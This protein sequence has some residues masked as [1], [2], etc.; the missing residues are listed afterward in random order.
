MV[1]L[2]SFSYVGSDPK[3]VSMSNAGDCTPIASFEYFADVIDDVIRSPVRE[4]YWEPLRAKT[5][6]MEQQWKQAQ[7]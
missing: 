1:T 7:P 3:H 2:S 4:G 6:H 5:A